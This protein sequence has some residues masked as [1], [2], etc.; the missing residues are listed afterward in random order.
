MGLAQLFARVSRVDGRNGML[1]Q[2]CLIIIE[3]GI[4]ERSA[5][6]TYV[7]GADMSST[8]VCVEEARPFGFKRDVC[9]LIKDLPGSILDDEFDIPIG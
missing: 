4:V 3:V 7:E 8:E 9:R 1:V 6:F 5:G 2:P